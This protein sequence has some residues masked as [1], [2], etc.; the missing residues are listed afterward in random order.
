MR[1]RIGKLLSNAGPLDAKTVGWCLG[2]S[3]PGRE[4][5]ATQL[6]THVVA[7][8]LDLTPGVAREKT[9]SPQ[10]IR[11]KWTLSQIS[12]GEVSDAILL[13]LRALPSPFSRSSAYEACASLTQVSVDV[14][15]A[16][17]FCQTEGR[18]LHH[19]IGT[20]NRK[21]D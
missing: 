10:S 17:P 7:A 6:P 20:L 18:D 4:S 5:F 21:T 3:R 14:F 11:W 2:K 1:N 12:L 16:G 13:A 19:L 8:I 9:N 15:I